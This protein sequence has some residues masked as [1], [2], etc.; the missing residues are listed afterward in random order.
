MPQRKLFKI[1]RALAILIVLFAAG[2]LVWW[3]LIRQ[4]PI[5]HNVIVLSGRIEGDD[6]TIAAKVAGRIR[7]I[8]VREG[9][10]LKAGSVIA[11][12]E[13]EQAAAREQQASSSLQEAQTRV[14]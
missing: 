8:Q 5:P 9:D 4:P 13:D 11:I 3:F 1:I 10:S 2:F 7:E 6:S 14:T 12:M